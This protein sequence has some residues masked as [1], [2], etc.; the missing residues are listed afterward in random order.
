MRQQWMDKPVEIFQNRPGCYHIRLGEKAYEID[1]VDLGSGRYSI[2]WG[3]ESYEVAVTARDLEHFVVH[4]HT[5]V[6]TLS[7]MHPMLEVLRATQGKE[8]QGSGGIVLAPMPAKVIKVEVG[9][10]AHVEQGTPLMILEAMKMQ[11]EIS[12]PVTGIIE[13]IGVQEGGGVERGEVLLEIR[14]DKKK[15]SG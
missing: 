11:N 4:T 12:A 14:P 2:L 8:L 15:E 7:L 6:Y 9:V 5:G 13:K 1:V 3:N 10:G